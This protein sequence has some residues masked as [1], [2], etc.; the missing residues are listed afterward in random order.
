MASEEVFLDYGSE[1]RQQTVDVAYGGAELGETAA[2]V[3]DLLQE[4]REGTGAGGGYRCDGEEGAGV[5]AVVMA[6]A[7]DGAKASLDARWDGRDGLGEEADG[8]SG[9]G[10]EGEGHG[11]TLPDGRGSVW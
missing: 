9:G 6:R 7:E 11:I 2:V 8:S 1:V 4:L 10:S 3:F 5:G